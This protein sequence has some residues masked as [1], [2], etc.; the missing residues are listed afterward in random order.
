MLYQ[1][2]AEVEAWRQRDPLPNFHQYL[3]Q[4]TAYTEFELQG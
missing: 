1:A 4:H 3:L 2:K